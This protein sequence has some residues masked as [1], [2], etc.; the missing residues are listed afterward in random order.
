MFGHEFYHGTL[1]KYVIIFGTL[2]ND[3][4]ISRTDDEGNRVQDLKI[5][6]AYGPADKTLVR[7][8]Q[9][10]NLDREMAITLPRMSFEMTN[11]MYASERKLN[12]VRKNV[13]I[14]DDKTKVR[15]MYQPV[16]YD[17]TF[18]LNVFCKYV[19]DG[20]KII[21]Q[22]LPFFTPEFT[23]S[24][25]ILPKM[26]WQIDIPVVL[27]S[28]NIQDTYENDFESRRA[29]IY[30]FT[31]TMKAQLF[32]PVTNSAIIKTAN[33]SF[34]VDYSATFANTHMSNV[35]YKT[36]DTDTVSVLHN[37][38]IVTP[39]LLANGSPTTNASLSIATSEIDADDNYGYIVNIEEFFNGEN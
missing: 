23:V 18:E 34:Y 29:L 8:E 21:E 22:I 25:N 38:T 15:R 5:P 20:T 14:S 32:G 30:T 39:G 16:P 3:I 17:L 6:L 36:I 35:Q 13:Y 26:N 12:T 33:T 7:L 24:A 31:F 28:V 1:R 37:R 27:D 10:P 2:F 4:I 9:D 19:E 11:F